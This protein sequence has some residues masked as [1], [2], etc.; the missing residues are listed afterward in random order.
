[1]NTTLKFAT[2]AVLVLAIG[3]AID[4]FRPR[5]PNAAANP[6]PSPVPSPTAPPLLCLSLDPLDAGTYALGSHI[7]PVDNPL[8]RM[9][10]TVPEGWQ[11]IRY[12]TFAN[13][14]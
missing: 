11:G 7:G 1:M 9:T 10:A 5:S 6:S 13:P 8:N 12:E 4:P 14:F 3:V 2:I